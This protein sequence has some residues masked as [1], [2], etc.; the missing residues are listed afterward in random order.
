M[1][2]SSSR[3]V[4]C[5]YSQLLLL[6][7]LLIQSKLL[8]FPSHSMEAQVILRGSKNLGFGTVSFTTSKENGAA[9]E[10]DIQG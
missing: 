9:A 6:V 2:G 10:G 7:T 8:F 1:H 4:T 3:S 5:A